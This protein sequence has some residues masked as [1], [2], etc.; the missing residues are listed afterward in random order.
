MKK[1]LSIVLAGLVAIPAS[2]S[3][4]STALITAGILAAKT[5]LLAILAALL[6]LSAAALG[7]V[8]VYRFLHR[9]QVAV[10]HESNDENVIDTFEADQTW[11]EALE[12]ARE[13]VLIGDSYVGDDFGE[14]GDGEDVSYQCSHCGQWWSVG[15]LMDEGTR[16]EGG[17][18]WGCPGCL[19]YNEQEDEAGEDE[20]VAADLYHPGPGPGW[21]D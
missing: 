20:G 15:E 19:E 3:V 17:W 21:K 9:H 1:F 5:A 2:A 7:A 8:M 4:V 10:E 11:D 14:G 16:V 6:G 12:A 18:F 13:N